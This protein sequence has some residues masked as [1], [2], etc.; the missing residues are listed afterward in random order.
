MSFQWQQSPEDVFVPGITRWEAQLRAGLDD[1]ADQGAL[2]AEG[3]MQSNA[4]W[5]DQTKKARQGLFAYPFS[6]ETSFGITASYSGAINPETNEDYSYALELTTFPISG[7]LSI[8]LTRRRPSFL[9]EF[10]RRWFDQVKA[11]L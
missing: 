4:P 7:I 10:A 6:D 11:R 8:I 2:Q 9:G 5:K 1:L 3:F